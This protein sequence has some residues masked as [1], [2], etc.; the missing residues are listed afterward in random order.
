M[1]YE[2]VMIYS[3]REF[4]QIW[5]LRSE[6]IYNLLVDAALT[7]NLATSHQQPISAKVLPYRRVLRTS[8]DSI[9]LL[10]KVKE[11]NPFINYD[12]LEH[13]SVG[14]WHGKF[15]SVRSRGRTFNPVTKRCLLCIYRRS[16]GKGT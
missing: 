16:C 13:P 7:W 15:L 10:E 5:R 3:N 8:G 6:A 12:V 11:S 2:G 1:L 14:V 9:Q 4:V